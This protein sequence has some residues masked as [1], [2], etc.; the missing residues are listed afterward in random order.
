MDVF[1][2]KKRSRMGKFQLNN[3][4][5]EVIDIVSGDFVMEKE[6]RAWLVK[7]RDFPTLTFLH[8]LCMNEG[9]DD[10][11]IRYVGGIWA[12]LI[13]KMMMVL[14]IRKISLKMMVVFN[15]FKLTKKLQPT[16]LEFM[17]H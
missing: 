4:T 7:V 10:F 9:F 14:V 2:S 13:Q 17:I 1:I 11:I 16:R 3:P 12:F 5:D 15:L 6:K 8:M